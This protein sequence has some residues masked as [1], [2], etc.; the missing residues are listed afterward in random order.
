M[1]FMLMVTVLLLSNPM[2]A[3]GEKIAV[4]PVEFSVSMG[5]DELADHAVR[6]Q[7]SV[8]DAIR[9]SGHEEITITDDNPILSSAPPMDANSSC[10]QACLEVLADTLDVFEI[11]AVSVEKVG[12]FAYS[13][14]IRFAHADEIQMEMQG[15][16]FVILSEISKRVVIGLG[17]SL[18]RRADTPVTE[19]PVTDDSVYQN[20]EKPADMYD[21]ATVT[22]KPAKKIQEKKTLG[23][24]PFFISLGVTGIL[25]VSVLVIDLVGYTWKQELEQRPDGATSEEID[26]LEQLWVAEWV[27][28]GATGAGVITSAIL[29]FMT[30]FK[31]G[32]QKK[33][34]DTLTFRAR[35]GFF[36]KGAMIA[37]Q[38]EF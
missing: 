22:I 29:L 24:T 38:G 13:I 14:E 3:F 12:E 17:Q 33:K 19:P 36:K 31:Y 27:L 21:A 2:L 23:P 9:S 15:G 11:V 34:R 16:F 10:D 6:I 35:P 1:R 28:I 18:Q 37:F 25:G 20:N 5:E 7:D 32:N 30:D 8:I 4:L 26:T